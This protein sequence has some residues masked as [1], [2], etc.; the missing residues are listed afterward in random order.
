MVSRCLLGN[1]TIFTLHASFM[2]RH[3]CSTQVATRLVNKELTQTVIGVHNI[4][5]IYAT[6][7]IV[8]MM[9]FATNERS[10][11]ST[12]LFMSD[13]D[14]I[15]NALNWFMVQQGMGYLSKY[16]TASSVAASGD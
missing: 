2:S 12:W 10:P 8:N 16:S 5:Y 3:T 15:D 7:L 6:C 14:S 9:S 4:D 13:K 1:Y 11:L